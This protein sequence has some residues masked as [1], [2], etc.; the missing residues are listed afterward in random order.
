M[1]WFNKYC[2]NRR[3]HSL[4]YSLYAQGFHQLLIDMIQP[5]R[6]MV[7][8]LFSQ[9]HRERCNSRFHFRSPYLRVTAI[10][11][12]YCAERLKDQLSK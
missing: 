1:H 6:E 2:Y 7:H 11:A 10:L 12:T 3:L 4:F 9:L 5:Q 8:I